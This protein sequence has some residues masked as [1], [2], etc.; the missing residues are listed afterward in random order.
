MITYHQL[1]QK[2]ADVKPQYTDVFERL[3]EYLYFAEQSTFYIYRTDTNAVLARGV[4]GFE[5]AKKRASQLRQLHK[6]GFDQVKFK[7]ERR[8]GTQAMWTRTTGT[9]T[10][11]LGA[12]IFNQI[13]DHMA[14]HEFLDFFDTPITTGVITTLNMTQESMSAMTRLTSLLGMASFSSNKYRTFSVIVS[15]IWA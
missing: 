13:F 15:A 6:L 7:S 11:G 5:Q 2:L 10:S 9:F 4:Q 3:E 14:V 12:A 8:A 1:R